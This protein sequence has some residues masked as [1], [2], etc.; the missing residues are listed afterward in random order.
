M[1]SCWVGVS[2]Q[3][4]K[5]DK[6]VILYFKVLAT[7]NTLMDISISHHHGSSLEFGSITLLEVSWKDVWWWLMTTDDKQKQWATYLW[8]NDWKCLFG[9]VGVKFTWKRAMNDQSQR[10]EK[11]RCRRRC[12]RRSTKMRYLGWFARLFVQVR[13]AMGS[14]GLHWWRPVLMLG[15]RFPWG[16]LWKEGHHN[17]EGLKE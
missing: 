11:R 2:M 10:K 3:F 1:C 17:K 9:I 4:W 14:T 12:R 6:T 13:V 7:R 5:K 8:G 15:S 16:G